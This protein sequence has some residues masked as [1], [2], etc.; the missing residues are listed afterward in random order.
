MT[1]ARVWAEVSPGESLFDVDAD[2]LTACHIAQEQ[3]LGERSMKID[4]RH[5]EERS[6]AAIQLFF[7]L[8]PQFQ[9]SI[10]S[11]AM[12]V[13][14]PGFLLRKMLYF[15]SFVARTRSSSQL[16]TSPLGSMIEVF[17]SLA[18]NCSTST[19]AAAA[20]SFLT[21]LSVTPRMAVSGL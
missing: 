5:C 6:D 12:T 9:R 7:A 16:M 1:A 19:N 2:R 20:V 8:L 14:L 21:V 4:N 17:S 11:L 18:F 13:V 15:A 3:R 10:A